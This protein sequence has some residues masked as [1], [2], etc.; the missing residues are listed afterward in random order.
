[1]TEELAGNLPA[2]SLMLQVLNLM[3]QCDW[4]MSVGTY[5]SGAG[6]PR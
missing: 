6:P 1:M 5:K 3:V 2:N 4:E